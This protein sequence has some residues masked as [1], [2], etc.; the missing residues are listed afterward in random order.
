MIPQRR[1]RALKT[2]W[3]NIVVEKKYEEKKKERKYENI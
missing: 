1:R 3:R 2:N